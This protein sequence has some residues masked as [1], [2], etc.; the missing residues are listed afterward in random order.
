MQIV[1]ISAYKFVS[2]DD[3]PV[4]RPEMRARCEAHGLKGTILLAP[5]GIN[6]FLAGVREAIDSFLGWLHADP[7]FADIEPKESL[8]ENQPFKRMLVREKKEI[9]T[10]KMPLIRPE[11]G[12]APAVTPVELKRWLD[13][14]HDDAGRP[15]VMLDTRNAF[16]VAV[17][18]FEQAV[19]YDIAKFSDFP[20]AIAAHKAE[21]AGKTIVSFCTGGIRCE[22][23][24]IHMQEAGIEHVY[25][26]EGGI[27]K[28]FEEVGGSHYQGDCFVFDYRTALNPNLEPAGPKQCFACRAVVTAEEQQSPHYVVGKSCPHCIG[29]GTGTAAAAA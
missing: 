5:E 7:R 28:Y 29:E 9:I 14:G 10:M 3:I 1:N 21:F 17:G 18:T 26:L 25:Q 11:A 12:R 27:L 16:E 22:K 15:V 23:A 24:A 13:Q 2:L 19:D 4:L 20:P 6:L 8:S